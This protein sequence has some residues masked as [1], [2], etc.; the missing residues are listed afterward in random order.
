MLKRHGIEVDTLVSDT[1]PCEQFANRPAKLTPLERKHDNRFVAN[2]VVDKRTGV[3]VQGAARLRFLLR[4]RRQR[5]DLRRV[6]AVARRR[7]RDRDFLVVHVLFDA[8]EQR[9]GHVAFACIRQ[10]ADDVR[11][12]FGTFCYLQCRRHRGA[13]RRTG[14]DPFLPRQRETEFDRFVTV[15]R[16][17]L[18]DQA[19]AA[20]RLG[21]ARDEVGAP[22][23]HQ[24]RAE[25][26]MALARVAQGIPR[27]R[28]TTAEHG[29]VVGLG[30]DNP[31]ARVGRLEAPCNTQQRAA[32][33][34][35]A[36][37]SMQWL[38][39]EVGEYLLRRRALVNLGIRLVFEL[40][41]QEPAVFVGE[42]HGLREHA[43]AFVRGG[44]QDHRRAEESQQLAALEAEALGHDDH[45]RIALLRAHHRE[46]DAGIA[47]RCLDDR[48]PRPEFAALLRALDDGASHAVLD[49]TQRVE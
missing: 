2:D 34:E 29:G 6:E 14:K 42:F 35:P 27:L 38:A 16:Y 25:I 21:E 9:R 19:L 18:I 44:R 8:L 4:G 13:A 43:G 5:T 49:R 17:D 36:H 3:F 46:A 22:A 40:A 37:E 11:T 24:V 10:H 32:G 41:A 7:T 30:R 48:L 12:G 47:A 23:L 15:D 39:L 31:Y 26:R 1:E 20:R 28:Y 33:S 45:E